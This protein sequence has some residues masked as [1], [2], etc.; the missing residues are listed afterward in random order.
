VSDGASPPQSVDP[1]APHGFRTG[2][3]I[4]HRKSTEI[5]ESL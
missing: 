1:K 2:C 4:I 3:I 5:M